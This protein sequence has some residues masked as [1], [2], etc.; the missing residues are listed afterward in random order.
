MYYCRHIHEFSSHLYTHRRFWMDTSDGAPIN[1]IKRPNEGMLFE[2]MVF[3]STSRVVVS[4]R[5]SAKVHRSPLCL[6]PVYMSQL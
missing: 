6:S 3:A 1:I 2:R 4:Q 5:V